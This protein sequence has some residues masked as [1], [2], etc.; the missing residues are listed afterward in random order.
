M[1]NNIHPLYTN[2]VVRR[3]TEKPK[4]SPGGIHLPENMQEKPNTGVVVA[5]GQGVPMDDGTFRPL[6]VKVGDF[7]IFDRKAGTEFKQ[8]DDTL[9]FMH[10]HSVFAIY[11]TI[12]A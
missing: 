6:V 5:V 10:E 9:L 11:E 8:G 1:S 4:T 7:V 2:I 3:T 12:S